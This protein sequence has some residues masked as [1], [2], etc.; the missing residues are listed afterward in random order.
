M[1]GLGMTCFW[2]GFG[3]DVDSLGAGS[4]NILCPDCAM[5]VWHVMVVCMDCFE[6]ISYATLGRE[7]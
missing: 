3:L 7:N 1:C 4:R 2:P 5:F 6:G